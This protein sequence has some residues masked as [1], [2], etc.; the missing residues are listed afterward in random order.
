M[1]NYSSE[2]GLFVLN[3]CMV[4][5]SNS[6]V[7]V[8]GV[9]VSLVLFVRHGCKIKVLDMVLGYSCTRTEVW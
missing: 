6:E 9:V 8:A 2:K 1:Q 4:Q 3:R 5:N 7:G